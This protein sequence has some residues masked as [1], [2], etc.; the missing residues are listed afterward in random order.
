MF[1][2]FAVSA[3]TPGG[4]K[5]SFRRVQPRRDEVSRNLSASPAMGYETWKSPAR[6]TSGT[7]LVSY[8]DLARIRRVSRQQDG[9][10]VHIL[11]VSR[12]QALCRDSQPLIWS[13]RAHGWNL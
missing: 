11:M 13:C 12:H 4:L 5:R 6:A 3:E 2:D 10:L 9:V 8:L 1:A 7:S